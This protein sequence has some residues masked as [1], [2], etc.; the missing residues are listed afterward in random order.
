MFRHGWFLLPD[1]GFRRLRILRALFWLGSGT[2]NDQRRRLSVIHGFP[3]E[4]QNERD[5]SATGPDEP[6]PTA[7]RR[8]TRA[9]FRCD[10]RSNATHAS[11]TDPD[12]RHY[13]RV[14]P[15]GARFAFLGHALMESH[16]G[17]IV[18]DCRPA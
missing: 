6:P 7:G 8:N 1:E 2:M 17:L 10:K 5:H 18:D 11:T 16:S 3:Q 14:P 13:A 4:T 15:W 9:D 12:T